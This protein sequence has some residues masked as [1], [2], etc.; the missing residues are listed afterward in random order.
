MLHFSE[1]RSRRFSCRGLPFGTILQFHRNQITK[2]LS[3]QNF[4]EYR[5]FVLT[6]RIMGERL[7]RLIETLGIT[8]KEFAEAI[9]IGKQS[10]T[11]II[12]GR[13]KGFS[14]ESLQQIR[15]VFRVNLNWL[16]AGVGPM[17]IDE[18]PPGFSEEDLAILERFKALKFTSSHLTPFEEDPRLLRAWKSLVDIPNNSLSKFLEI[19]FSMISEQKQRTHD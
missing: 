7:K 8:Q 19:W 16:I 11:E 12:S 6:C 15:K 18:D 13:V 3:I 17:F 9:G 10:I 5:I 2:D 4:H 14:T 1:F